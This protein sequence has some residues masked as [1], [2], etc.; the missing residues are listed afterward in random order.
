M[1]LINGQGY[2]FTSL[3][4]TMLG[5]PLV[6]GLKSISYTTTQ[7]K[8]NA[9]GVGGQPVERTRGSID[10]SGSIGLT[11]KEVKQLRQATGGLPVTQIPSFSISI[12]FANDVDPVITD[13][14]EFVEF[15]EDPTELSEGDTDVVVTLPII[16]GN[17]KYNQ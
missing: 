8:N 10:Y 1:A 14:L 12:S 2:D 15:T 11:L 16:I 6:I 9:K 13:V 7:E 5:N 17:I 4:V 3:Q